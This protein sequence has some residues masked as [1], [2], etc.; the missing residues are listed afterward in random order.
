V[1]RR[2][3]PLRVGSILDL[4]FAQLPAFLGVSVVVIA[5][6]GPDTALTIRNALIGGRRHGVLTATGVATGQAVWALLTAF[7]VASLLQAYEPALLVLRI[8][9]GGYLLFLGVH[10]LLSVRRGAPLAATASRCE[11]HLRQLAALRQGLISN[12]ANPK[13][14]VFFLSLLPQFTGR[15]A[16]FATLFALGILFSLLTFLWLS[17]Y[18][19]VVARAGDILKRRKIRQL[20]DAVTGTVLVALGLRIATE[21]G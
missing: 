15:H 4:V 21:H 8:A 19:L 7:G 17:A 11:P 1:R 14:V 12:L 16:G 5:T 20:M 13:M 9:G 6:P 18:S 10:A 2:T 3:I